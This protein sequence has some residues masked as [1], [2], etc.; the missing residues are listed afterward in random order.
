MRLY[1]GCKHNFCLFRQKTRA[2]RQEGKEI[3]SLIGEEK[4]TIQV[5]ISF[6]N[7]IAF[8]NNHEVHHSLLPAPCSLLP[9]PYSLLPTPYSQNKDS[10]ARI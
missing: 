3:R 9:A 5:Y 7:A 6:R 8:P 2:K 4:K 10:N 1:L